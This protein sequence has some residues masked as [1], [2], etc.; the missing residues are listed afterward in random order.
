M[1]PIM[2]ETEPQEQ[3]ASPSEALL[4]RWVGSASVPGSLGY[5]DIGIF[6]A[7]LEVSPG[8]LR[9]RVRPALLRLVFGLQ[10][11]QAVP[12]D[13]TRIFPAR[14]FG[15]SGIEIRREHMRSYYFWTGRRG[16]LLSS[17]AAAGFE[18]STDEQTMSYR[19]V[20]RDRI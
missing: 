14:K 9:F 19:T 18:V 16:D 10:V 15:Q 20:N 5:T 11:L 6:L 12:G 1:L 7:M 17:V 2:A 8:V 4:Q 13:G 3:E